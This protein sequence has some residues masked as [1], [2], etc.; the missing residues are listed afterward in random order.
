MAIFSSKNFVFNWMERKWSFS[1]QTMF[2]PQTRRTTFSTLLKN[3]HPNST[4]LKLKFLRTLQRDDN[5]LKSIS[6]NKK[7]CLLTVGSQRSNKST[8]KSNA[9]TL[10]KKT[11]ARCLQ[12]STSYTHIPKYA[13]RTTLS[14]KCRLITMFL[15][16]A[17]LSAWNVSQ[18][19]LFTQL[20]MSY[21]SRDMRKN[22]QFYSF[23]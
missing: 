22:P 9:C 11:L 10:L 7:S 5:V 12:F 21:S 14:P 17:I 2:N 20:S 6:S 8:I 4:F 16:S 13:Q 3:S 23:S 18:V 1:H 19:C 15:Y